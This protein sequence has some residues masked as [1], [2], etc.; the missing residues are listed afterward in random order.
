MTVTYVVLVAVTSAAT[1]SSAIANFLRLERIRAGMNR[2]GVPT[3][4]LPWL[5]VPTPS[6]PQL[7]VVC[8]TARAPPDLEP[9]Y[10]TSI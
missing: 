1:L 5:G 6:P 3:G 4:L 2:I 8:A 9:K 10:R 7:L